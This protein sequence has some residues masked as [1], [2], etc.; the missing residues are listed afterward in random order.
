MTALT[1][2]DKNNQYNKLFVA[3][4]A[5]VVKSNTVLLSTFVLG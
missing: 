2:G 1:Y 3:N 5:D 4:G